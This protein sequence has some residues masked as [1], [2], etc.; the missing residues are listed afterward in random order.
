MKENRL[1]QQVNTIFSAFITLCYFGAG[2]YFILAEKVSDQQKLMWM[3]VGS[4]FIIYG[5]YRAYRTYIKIVEVFFSE[6]DNN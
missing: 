4:T 3:I 6:D 5:I 2:L 1:M